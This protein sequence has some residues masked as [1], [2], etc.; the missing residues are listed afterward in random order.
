MYSLLVLGLVPG[1]NFQITF[2]FWLQ[3]FGA[4]VAAILLAY[5]GLRYVKAGRAGL[6]AI[7][8]H[9]FVV[10]SKLPRRSA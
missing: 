7:D 1:T 8:S 10:P 6:K 9:T 4:L 2:E 3:C 5:L